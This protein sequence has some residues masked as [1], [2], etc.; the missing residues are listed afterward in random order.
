M[1]IDCISDLHGEYPEL[2]GGDLLILAGD[3]TGSNK[4]VQWVDFFAWLSLQKYSKK[5]FIGGNHDGFLSQCISTKEMYQIC[6]KED[7]A[8]WN[9]TCEYLCDSGTEFEY[10][11]EIEE[12][13]KFKGPIKYLVK[14]KLKI[15]GSPWSLWFRAI[16]PHCK[17]FTTTEGELKKK[18]ALIPSDTDI[19]ITHSPRFG[20]LDKNKFRQ[21]CGSKSLA[22]KILTLKNL[23]LHVFGHIHE[24]YGQCHQGYEAKDPWDPNPL[25]YGHLSVNCSLMDGDYEAVNEPMRVIL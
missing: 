5:I 2:E 15:W 14:K 12:D 25:P 4:T 21:S 1:I 18:F 20:M 7:Y 19:L 9:G 6:H 13:H 16:N 17:S 3:Y 8:T 24:A 10:E 23:K 22:D 11:V